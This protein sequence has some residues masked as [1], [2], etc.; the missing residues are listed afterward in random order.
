MKAVIQRVSEA[1]VEV[2]GE[3]TGAI[4]GGILVLLGVEQGD[5]EQ[6]ADWLV[7]KIVELRIFEDEAGKMNLALA[8]V[9]GAL[10]VVSQF[11]LLGDCR[12][13]RRPSFV[14]AAPPAEGNRLY[15]YF[16]AKA[17]ETG[18]KVETGVFQAMMQVHLI[19]DGPVTFILESR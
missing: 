19:N 6:D 2:D 12:K 13:G 9:N 10:L 8:E 16:V 1:R 11:T 15:E 3:V 17:R 14:K 18:T 5:T 4:G 7:K